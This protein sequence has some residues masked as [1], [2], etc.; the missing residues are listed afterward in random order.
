MSIKIT[1]NE[2]KS[3]YKNI[4]YCGYCELQPII[5]ESESKFYNAGMYGW[6]Y[7]AYE[8]NNNTVILSGYRGTFGRELSPEA[9][10]ILQKANKVFNDYSI[11]WTDREK[12]IK[13]YRKQFFK[14][15][16]I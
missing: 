13:Y 16:E 11:S 10:K 12:K 8:I 1:R 15:F 6:N 4:Y 2:L 7:S 9:K 5:R 3:N 14:C